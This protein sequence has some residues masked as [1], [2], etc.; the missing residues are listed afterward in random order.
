MK[1]NKSVFMGI[2][3]ILIVIAV[4]NVVLFVLMDNRNQMFWI[5]YVFTM[6][7][8]VLPLLV[9]ISQMN[10]D[11]TPKK[12]FLGLS[13]LMTIPVYI[14][15]QVIVGAIFMFLP[16]DLNKISVIVQVIILAV[17][18]LLFISSLIVKDHA[19]T[20][21]EKVAEKRIYIQSLV[22]DVQGMKDRANDALLKKNLSALEDAFKYSDPMSHES[23]APLENKIASLTAELDAMIVSGD[24]DAAQAKIKEIEQALT[25][26]NRKTK[27]LK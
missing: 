14:I 5:S 1:K 27:L 9:F 4:Y 3:A 11:I 2:I 12:T 25:E 23:L 7:A 6:I 16:E 26:R 22:V 24:Q 19:E 15:I 18:A 20:F 17:F 21:D 10:K 8:L 13:L